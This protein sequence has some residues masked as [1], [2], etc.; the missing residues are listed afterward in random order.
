MVNIDALVHTT[1]ASIRSV[2][3]TE[4]FYLVSILFDLS[5]HFALTTLCVAYLV[6]YVR[7]FKYSMLFLSSLLSGMVITTIIKY[8]SN[9]NRPP[10]S[11]VYAFGQSFPSWHAT[12][13]AVFFIMLIYIFDDLESYY[14]RI[15]FNILCVA[16]IF[17]VAFS[18]VYLGAHWV[19][20]V[21][22]GVLLGCLVSIVSINISNK[23]FH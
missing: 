8:V 6:Y 15:F 17:L 19:S 20:D 2:G 7:G 16:G 11:L 12:V 23:Y 13:A 1:I 3:I 9:V 18:R 5:I 21:S 4:F 22:F 14:F 10:D